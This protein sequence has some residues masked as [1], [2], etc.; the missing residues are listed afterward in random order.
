VDSFIQA[1]NI[2]YWLKSRFF[3]DTFKYISNQMI[4]VELP[5]TFVN[6]IAKIQNL[7]GDQGEFVTNDE[8]MRKLE[9]YLSQTG[10]R[11]GRIRKVTNMNT[12]KECFMFGE[13]K[14]LLVL[15]TDLDVP[16]SVQRD[17]EANSEYEINFRVQISA[18]QPNAFI[19][20]IDKDVFQPIQTNT[21]VMSGI[22][23]A[24][25]EGNDSFFSMAIAEPI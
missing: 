2:G 3:D 21:V 19:M 12:G 23:S 4:Q 16:E 18:W 25:S 9:L 22:R 15:F 7:F 5:K 24:V 10:R 6:V 13:K 14:N 8:D 17:A 20:K 11:S 1:T